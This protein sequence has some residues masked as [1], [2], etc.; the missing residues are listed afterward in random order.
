MK[1]IKEKNKQLVIYEENIKLKEIEYAA[2]TLIVEN[3]ISIFCEDPGDFKNYK[4]EILKTEKF[5]NYNS[6]KK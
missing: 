3:E 2:R 5:K 6:R 4:I 1:I